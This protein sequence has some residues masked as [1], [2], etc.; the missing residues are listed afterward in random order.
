MNTKSGASLLALVASLPLAARADEG[1]A[2]FWIPGQFGSLAAVPTTPGWS[3]PLLYLHNSASSEVSRL[4]V[5]GGGVVGGVDVRADSLLAFPTYT[6]ETPVLGGQ[7]ALGLGAGPGSMDAS[8][9]AAFRPAGGS[10]TG[11]RQSDSVS[12]GSDLYGQAT[13]KW[14]QGVNNYMVYGMFGA[15]LGAYRSDRLSNL[16]LNHWSMDTGGGY[17]Y[18]DKKNEFS[19]VLGVTYNFENTDTQYRNGID[20]H[21]DWA[22]SRFVTEQ[23][24][25]GLAGYFYRQLT[26]DSG[27]GAVLGDHKSSV[28]GIAPQ[29]GHFFAVNQSQWYVDVKAYKEF[30]AVNR[31]SGWNLWVS[32]LIPLSATKS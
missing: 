17:T 15:P 11:A 26:G 23:T 6:F 32:L 14:N 2:G 1:G 28:N 29:L 12:G 21:L 3:L 5:R 18:F 22:T 24:H 7:A 16:G 8:V 25:V 20:A 10:L 13:L 19:A 9:G 31:P 30:G 4:T 27:A